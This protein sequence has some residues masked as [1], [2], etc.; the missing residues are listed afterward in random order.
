MSTR[1][2]GHFNSFV[3]PASA[4]AAA[5]PQC[6]QCLLPMNIKPKHEGQ[7]TVASLDSQKVQRDAADELAAPQFGQL[8]VLASIRC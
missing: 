3:S 4:R 2:R 7:P 5:V 8:S 6:G 1:Q